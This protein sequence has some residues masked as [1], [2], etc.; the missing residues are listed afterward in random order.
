[1]SGAPQRLTYEEIQARYPELILGL[2]AHP[3]IGWVLVRSSENG[4]MVLSDQGIHYLDRDEVEGQQDPLAVYGPNA[5]EHLKRE[6]SFSTCPDLL[7]NTRYNPATQELC[8]FENQVSHH[9]GLGGWQNY[10]FIFHPT[11]LPVA[12]QPIVGATNVYRLLRGWRDAL[13]GEPAAA[14][15]QAVAALPAG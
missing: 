13:Q 1:V 14:E 15:Q 8:G 5:A 12:S 3:G 9:G 6:S 4:D 7:V 2:I 10:P 11:S